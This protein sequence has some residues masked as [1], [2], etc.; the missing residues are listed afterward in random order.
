[1]HDTDTMAAHASEGKRAGRQFLCVWVEIRG[2]VTFL[3]LNAFSGFVFICYIAAYLWRMIRN[4]RGLF[5][6]FYKT[7]MQINREPGFTWMT[8]PPSSFQGRPV[9]N[10]TYC[11]DQ[12][13]VLPTTHMP[14]AF[15]CV[16]VCVCV[17][18]RVCVCVSVN[19]HPPPTLRCLHLS[20]AISVN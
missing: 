16:C 19:N 17:C 15:M 5:L 2:L 10:N 4:N 13:Q 18:V 11:R 20:D 12:E 7:V 9:N 1:M 14:R 8:P 6:L 3:R